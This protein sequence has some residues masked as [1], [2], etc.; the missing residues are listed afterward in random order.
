MENFLKAMQHMLPWLSKVLLLDQVQPSQ[1]SYTVLGSII[2]TL[3]RF[4]STELCFSGRSLT[5]MKRFYLKQQC[6]MHYYRKC[7]EA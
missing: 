2:L 6:E 4:T 1:V 3:L 5:D 7:K